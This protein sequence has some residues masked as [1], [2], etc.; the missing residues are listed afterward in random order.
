MLICDSQLPDDV[1]YK[2][3]KTFWENIEELYKVHAKAKEITLATA[4][5]GVSVPVHPGAAKY[6]QEVGMNVPDVK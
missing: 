1:V 5:D 3:T 4:L 6:Y 2:F